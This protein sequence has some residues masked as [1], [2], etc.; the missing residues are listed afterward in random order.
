MTTRRTLLKFIGASATSAL[1]CAYFGCD[2]KH[3]A[4]ASAKEIEDYLGRWGPI[5]RTELTSGVFTGDDFNHLAHK[6]LPRA[7]GAETMQD[8]PLAEAPEESSVVV[9]GGGVSGLFSAYLLR[10]HNPVVLERASRFGGNSKG[11][12][13]NGVDYSIGAAYFAEPDRGTALYKL[14]DELGFLKMSRL[15]GEEDP[16]LFNGRRYNDF[17]KGETDPA[18]ASQFL[19][20][21]KHFRDMLD[22]KNGLAT[23]E[24]PFYDE[25]ARPLVYRLDRIS[26]RDYLQEIV[27]PQR[28]HPHIE[29]ALEQ[30]CW[31][32][33]GAT[34]AQLSAACALGQLVPEFGG[35]YVPPGGNSALVEQLCAR[36]YSAVGPANLRT[37]A[38]AVDISVAGDRVLVKY[39]AADTKVRA[40]RCRAVI[41]ACPKFVVKTV[42]RGIEDERKNAIANELKYRA[43][44]VGN[45][46]LTG[47]VKEE[48]YDCYLLADGKAGAVEPKTISIEDGITDVI[49][50][51]YAKAGRNHTVLTLYRSYPWDEARWQLYSANY[52]DYQNRFRDRATR[53]I[54]SA[55]KIDVAAIQDIRMTRWGHAL[56][57]AAPG[58]ISRGVIDQIRK[59]FKQRVFFVEQDNWMQPAIE[60]CAEEALYWTKEAAKVL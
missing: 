60:T 18:N 51:N 47:P 1:S 4:R 23:P 24:V 31:S 14:F 15:K 7:P 44:V 30:Y 26:L 43:Y 55:L 33:C 37:S 2:A 34:M 52:D 16:V 5:A 21:H 58:L 22:G 36:L 40:I 56:P 35:I 28:L 10:R 13:W 54:L 12:S 8:A 57:V 53:E 9:V 17:W 41:M 39:V 42:L 3:S 27:K 59:P 19:L 49:L 6:Y 45:V 38:L 32:S 29:T 25:S 46:L 48:F 50:A 11:E 20:L